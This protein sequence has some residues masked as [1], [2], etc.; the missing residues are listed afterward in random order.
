MSSVRVDIDPVQICYDGSDGPT[1]S[2]KIGLK[3]SLSNLVEKTLKE[4][5]GFSEPFAEQHAALDAPAVKKL[6]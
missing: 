6:L 5:L 1:L 4:N 2:L 3:L